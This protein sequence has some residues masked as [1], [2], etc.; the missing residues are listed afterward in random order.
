M[1][2]PILT[3]EAF[4]PPEQKLFA[5]TVQQFDPRAGRLA[6]AILPSLIG[7]GAFLACAFVALAFLS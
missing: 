6:I 7:L 5:R 4:L 1:S 2:R 3:S